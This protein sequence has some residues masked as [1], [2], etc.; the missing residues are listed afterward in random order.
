[1]VKSFLLLLLL[2]FC[3]FPER[4]EGRT[5]RVRR[6]IGI[7][8]SIAENKDA[9]P[10]YKLMKK[11]HEKQDLEKADR[12]TVGDGEGSKY[13][14]DMENQGA[15]GTNAFLMLIQSPIAASQTESTRPSISFSPSVCLLIFLYSYLIH[16]TSVNN[17]HDE[18]RREG[19][20]PVNRGV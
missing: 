3:H 10:W 14:W 7:N 5:A 15:F 20:Q 12:L 1:M 4:A 16:S 6:I 9:N 19:H 18:D 17:W 13:V 11:F 8:I 2:L